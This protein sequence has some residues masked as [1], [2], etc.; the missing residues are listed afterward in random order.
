[1]LLVLFALLTLLL[2]LTLDEEQ[3]S[4]NSLPAVLGLA[5]SGGA[6]AM[7]GFGSETTSAFG[8]AIVIG[9]FS[10]YFGLL[11]LMLAS[12]LALLCTHA[13]GA[14][15]Q[16]SG[17]RHALLLLAT[18]GLMLLACANDLLVLF[19]AFET[20][21]VSLYALANT[22]DADRG[23]REGTLR[24]L[25]AGAFS[26][27]LLAYGFSLLYGLGGS[28]NLSVISARIAELSQISSAENLLIGMAMAAAGGGILLRIAGVP[29]HSKA[30]AVGET[31]SA[32]VVAFISVA[33][34]LA[35][36]TLLLRLLFSIFW[37]ER[38]DWSRLLIVAAV[39]AMAIGTIASLRQANIKRLLA[40]SAIAQGGYVLLAIAASVN[41]DGS[42]NA[43]SLGS[44]GYYLLAFVIF[45]IG[46]F[47]IAIVLRE[48]TA[49]T[50]D[51]ASL[52]GLNG[53]LRKHPAAGGAMI[54]LLLS[55]VG[56]PPTAGFVAKL[57]VVRVL[58]ANQRVA[59]AWIAVLF[60][61]PPVYP[62][63]R[64]IRAMI[65]PAAEP[66]ER[67]PLSDFQAVALAAMV[68][69]TLLLGVFPA[70]FEQ[71]AAQSL[72]ALVLH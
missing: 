32:A 29:L 48:Q 47:A 63:Y 4:W 45:Q 28:T 5:L 19:V 55:C 27:A 53:L 30:P 50:E 12:L 42:F 14:A 49:A 36:F 51:L 35:C 43:Q 22:G 39:L 64:I 18:A 71:F 69:L 10:G 1:M 7:V 16:Q 15:S 21:S 56:V 24:F 6:L 59:L 62:S 13:S 23:S 70:P 52:N 25:L 44:A 37:R 65:A 33:A 3:K 31:S 72:A 57:E 2:D 54:F 11:A 67:A 68:V 8:N 41:R 17:E 9:P 34:K 38:Y 46:A 61:I 58:F 66:A 60:A 40:Y 26:M 20:V